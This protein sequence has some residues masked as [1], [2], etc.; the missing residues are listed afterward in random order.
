MK[1]IYSAFSLMLLLSTTLPSVGTAGPMRQYNSELSR[2][3]SQIETG[4]LKQALAEI[5]RNNEGSDKDILYFLEKGELLSLGSD[6]AT[7]RDAWMKGDEMI[8]A[9]E[10]EFRT[11]PSQFFGDMGSYLISDKTR[12]YDGQDYEKVMLSTRLTLSHIML[13]NF[14]HARIEMKKTYEREKLIE[15]FREKEYEALSKEANKQETGEIRKLDG[16][17]MEELDTPEVRELK[18]GFQNAF[19]HYLTGYFFEVT[20]E[21]SL[22]EPGYRN[23]LQLAPGKAIIQTALDGVGK[24]P[25]DPDESDVLFVIET[26]FA[27][28]IDSLNIPIPIPRKNGVVVT[29]LSF[30]VIKSSSR[31]QVPASLLVAGQKLPVETLTNTDTMARR[32]LRDQMPGVILRTVVRAGVKSLVQEQA[33]KAH[34]I[35]GLIANVVAVTTEQADD[36]N[37]RTLPE[38]ISIARA[39]LRH[40]QHPIELQANAGSFRTEIE[41]TGRFT[42]I[43]IRITGSAVYAGQSNHGERRPNLI[44]GQPIQ[45]S[46]IGVSAPTD[47][48]P[49]ATTV[50]AS[51]TTVPTPL[52][53]A[54]PVEPSSSTSAPRSA[55]SL[56]KRVTTGDTTY[57]GDFRFAQPSGLPSGQGII[58]WSN[59]NRFEGQ[60]SHGSKQGQGLFISPGSFRYE[61]EWAGDL[62]NGRGIT[63]FET[64]DVYEG[65]MKNGNFHGQGTY[66]SKDGTRY[67]GQWQNGVKE[68]QGRLTFPDG[69]FWEGLFKNDERTDQGKMTIND[70]SALKPETEA[71]HAINP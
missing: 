6:Y 5:E 10:N 31:V 62:Q 16:Y 14:D 34:W 58:E 22:A 25:P 38:R 15:A 4:A 1:P 47:D 64:G 23:A 69:D 7:S 55:D 61:G 48:V 57:I 35:A 50:R 54:A 36:R 68:G 28:S 29:P 45:P 51:K 40:G 26:G 66:T 63:I 43:P 60:L 71:A 53:I 44:A 17:P 20:N 13:G 30:P 39:R 2:T 8:Q 19:S 32:L 65:E 24:S 27:P 18:N 49:L 59:G 3:V 67:T 33:N 41:V 9:W 52:A 21:P 56:G 70:K 12:R 11:N 42:I 46:N 37:W